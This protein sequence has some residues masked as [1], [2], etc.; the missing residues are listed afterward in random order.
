MQF[1]V[2]TVCIVGDRI[3]GYPFAHN[4]ESKEK[5][6]GHEH[7]PTV[8][9]VNIKCPL[10]LARKLVISSCLEGITTVLDWPAL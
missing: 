4:I 5:K 6:L 10:H 9:T 2:R 3:P 7:P 8:P 1:S